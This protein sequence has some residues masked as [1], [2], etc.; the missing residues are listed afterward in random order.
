MKKILSILVAALLLFS[1]ACAAG[2]SSK[3][4]HPVV[5]G[6][7]GFI[8]V[9]D[10]TIMALDEM[11][12]LIDEVANQNKAPIEHFDAETQAAIAAK[13][14]LD[15]AALKT[16]E[17]NEFCSLGVTEAYTAENGDQ[18]VTFAV[19]TPYAVGQKISVVVGTFDGTRSEVE[20]GKYAFNV[21]RTVLDGE[22][23]AAQTDVA[24]TSSLIQVTFP[25]ETVLE[26]QS[27]VAT[28]MA[29]LSEPAA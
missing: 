4:T 24:D 21:K 25:T 7:G 13:T 17:L 8:F 1:V 9:T 23:T 22:V 16:W 19:A 15:A 26:M 18:V 12:T 29:V 6:E 10:D 20:P 27:S 11:E 14:G 2:V 3:T 28:T 5:T